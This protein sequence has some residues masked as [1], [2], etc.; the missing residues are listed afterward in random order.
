MRRRIKGQF[1]IFV[2]IVFLVFICFVVVSVVAVVSVGKG[3]GS[4]D[5]RSVE[6]TASK[7]FSNF[8]SLFPA[9]KFDAILLCYCF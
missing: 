8:S 1:G 4:G 5:Y 7:E 9:V 3:C 6:K 2:A